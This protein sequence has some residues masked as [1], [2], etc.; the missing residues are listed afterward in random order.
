MLHA[1]LPNATPGTFDVVRYNQ[2]GSLTIVSQAQSI[3]KAV[4]LVN[5]LNVSTMLFKK[6]AL[7]DGYQNYS[8]TKPGT[9]FY[10]LNKPHTVTGYTMVGELVTDKYI[11]T[12]AGFE[13]NIAEGLITDV[14]F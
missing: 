9:T 5:E 11:F 10:Y 3:T 13:A 6:Q 1:I 8:A 7:P 12:A 4:K 2:N 14:V